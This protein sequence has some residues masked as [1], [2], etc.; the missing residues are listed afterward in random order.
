LAAALFD[1]AAR[2]SVTAPVVERPA[3]S[4]GHL[5]GGSVD[6]EAER[7]LGLADQ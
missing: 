3:V 6:V 5:C 7:L 4:F 1:A 2:S